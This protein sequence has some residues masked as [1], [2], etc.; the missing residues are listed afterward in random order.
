MNETTRTISYVGAALVAVLGAVFLSP[1]KPRAPSEFSEVGKTFY[2]DF[3]ATDAKSLDVVKFNEDTA[4]LKR[5]GVAF[6]NGL[7]VITSHRDYPADGK[8][9]LSKTAASMVGIRRE[10][11]KTSSPSDYAELGVI[12][13]EE[14]DAEKLKGRGT[15][16][17][18][19]TEDGHTLCDYIVG[20]PVK[21]HQGDF[22]VRR[23]DEKS[24]YVAKL[25]IDLSTKFSDWIEADLLQIQPDELRE[26]T[27]DDYTVD[28]GR[29]G[30]VQG[31]ISQLSRDSGTAPWKLKDLDPEKEEV[32]TAEVQKMVSA[33]DNLKIIG[34]R[35]KPEGLSQD[36]KLNEGVKLDVPTLLD[37]RARGFN[38]TPQG[39][40][41][42]N[43]G[44]LV[45]GTSQG[46]VY[47]IRFGQIF[48]G[49]EMELEAGLG[50][51]D[52]A[53]KKD[54]EAEKAGEKKADE[55][56]GSE[57]KGRYAFITCS[58]D[59]SL[60]GPKPVKPTRPAKNKP[61]ATGKPE[62]TEPGK[63]PDETKPEADEKPAE[64]EDGEDSKKPANCAEDESEAKV[65]AKD[66][67]PEAK[68]DGAQKPAKEPPPD[69]QPGADE[70]PEGEKPEGEKPAAPEVPSVI[71]L[72]YQ[73]ALKKYE[74]DQK[75][76]D[77]KVK[78]GKEKVKEL[79]SRFADWYYVLSADSFNQL[80]LGRKELVK[81][82]PQPPAAKPE[83]DSEGGDAK[84]PAVQQEPAPP[85]SPE[86]PE[87]AQDKDEK[88]DSAAKEADIPESR[89]PQESPAK[90]E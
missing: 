79:N 32:N 41:R 43:Q 58:F 19:K 13:P 66:E 24:V 16:I 31:D 44:D 86:A 15:R 23:P 57:Q 85:A 71:E 37:L 48:T 90:P 35:H 42:S 61:A 30:I 76:Y 82:R 51:E 10:E 6:R 40:L 5:F 49:S 21:G 74:A 1:S 28:E 56:K 81:P 59:P 78:A 84:K 53:A 72:Q 9:R 60:L 68:S 50:S 3:S 45:A 55:K 20:R 80:H 26:I 22:Y 29:G 47:V 38:F 8:D 33:L 12:D 67:Q 65:P 89:A 39:E 73:A 69:E 36:L 18:L 17:T 87:K 70:K 88:P 64:P 46:A 63:K 34:V 7:W 54:G 11:F 25:N 83:L 62:E 14:T 27:I 75:A 2:K 77:E 4:E 52:A